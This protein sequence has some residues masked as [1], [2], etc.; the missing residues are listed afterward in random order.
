MQLMA[1]D[2]IRWR[3]GS[4]EHGIEVGDRAVVTDIDD[5]QRNVQIQTG[6]GEERVIAASDPVFRGCDHAFNISAW[7]FGRKEDRNVIAVAD[8]SY[9]NIGIAVDVRAKLGHRAGLNRQIDRQGE[10]PLPPIAAIVGFVAGPDGS[11]A[12]GLETWHQ[13]QEEERL[14]N[15]T[16]RKREEELRKVQEREHG[17]G[18][19]GG[20]GFRM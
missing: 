3:R 10:K 18:Q 17:R 5:W 6:Q 16:E 14:R 9:P 15:D 4:E 12:R 2:R 20:R 8:T 1:G 11:I 19:G 13:E 7:E